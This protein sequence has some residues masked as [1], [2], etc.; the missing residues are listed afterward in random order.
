MKCGSPHVMPWFNNLNSL[1]AKTRT[2]NY[3]ETLGII[4][5]IK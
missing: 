1:V 4:Q 3:R 5:P 2:N